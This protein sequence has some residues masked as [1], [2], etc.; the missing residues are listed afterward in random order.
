MDKGIETIVFPF[1]S[2]GESLAL[3]TEKLQQLSGSTEG[4]F[5]SI[6]ARLQDYYFRAGSIDRLAS[7]VTAQVSGEE[8]QGAIEH[9]VTLLDKMQNYLVDSE[10]EAGLDCESLGNVLRLLEQVVEPLS[11]FSTI[12]KVLRML[13][14]STKIE[15]ARLGNSAAGFDTIAA[16]VANLSVQ[17]LEKSQTI[18]TQQSS[19][20]D[21]IRKTLEGVEKTEAEQ[22][23]RVQGILDKTRASLASLKEINSN[24]SVIASVVA[25]ASSEISKGMSEVVTSMQFH[26]IVRQQ[27]EHVETAL[28]ELH[29]RVTSCGSEEMDLAVEMTDICEL[30]AAQ[31]RQAGDEISDAV[32][33]IIDNLCKVSD[34][35]S[36]T[37]SKTREMAGVADRAGSSF[38]SDMAD[39]LKKIAAVFAS[40]AEA[41]KSITRAM[42]SVAGTV[43]EIVTYV[44]D[45]EHIGE[46]IELIA[47]NAQIKAARTGA[48]GAAL[49]VLAE[50][51]QRLSVEAQEQTGNVSRTLLAVTETTESL[52]HDVGEEAENLENEIDSIVNEL[53]SVLNSLRLLNE[54]IIEKV[55]SLEGEVLALSCDIESTTSSI[56]VHELMASGLSDVLGALN[57]IVAEAAALIP[58]DLAKGKTAR[59]Q[60]LA[61]RYTM[62]SE[63]K[64]HAG[65]AGAEGFDTFSGSG[66]EESDD[67]VELF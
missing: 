17:V 4:E 28:A 18:L 37:A 1:A 11:G 5:L 22:I 39:D 46:E 9:L 50:A 40:N 7:D 35:E 33:S 2:W 14:M 8:V 31:L 53:D 41:N 19:L 24:C 13:G 12:N 63:R 16:D 59:L 64:V 3:M 51:T 21:T 44:G 26:D 47:M 56:S 61:T 52:F 49:G 57:A 10:R 43:G 29:H 58:I 65:F 32:R 55:Q 48:E 38:F 62:H 45:I 30:Q 27:I 25:S 66:S 6:G 23:Q 42:T 15:S 20:C 36:N 67:N 60:E 34:K 54:N